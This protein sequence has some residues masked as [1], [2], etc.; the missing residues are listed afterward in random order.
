[1]FGNHWFIATG[2]VA[3]FMLISV[4]STR[5]FVLLPSQNRVAN[6][7]LNTTFGYPFDQTS[8]M[9]MPGAYRE[10]ND[11]GVIKDLEQMLQNTRYTVLFV[12]SND[13]LLY[14]QRKLWSFLKLAGFMRG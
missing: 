8:Y 13:V 3:G 9:S 4:S 2:F 10:S 11:A 7:T 1:M 12:G 5:H 6:G 14:A